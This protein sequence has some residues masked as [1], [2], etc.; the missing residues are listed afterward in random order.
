MYDGRFFH[1]F[2]RQPDISTVENTLLRYLE[3][4]DCK[5]LPYGYSYTGRTDR[6]ASSFWQT[7][8]LIVKRDC[9][10]RDFVEEINN[11]DFSIGIWGVNEYLP[12]Y[13]DARRSALWREYM[14]V[15]FEKN[16]RCKDLEFLSSMMKTLYSVRVFSFLYKDYKGLPSWY[17]DRRILRAKT[18]LF[19][20]NIVYLIRGESFPRY[21]VRRLVDFFRKMNCTDTFSEHAKRWVPGAASPEN[22][23]L[24]GAKYPFSFKKTRDIV[25]LA[26]KVFYIKK[27]FFV[28]QKIFSFLKTSS[29]LSSVL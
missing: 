26:N 11:S 18:V 7:L 15:D 6:G 21:F 24:L 23:V 17:L 16:Y 19:G 12:V 9:K 8:T 27:G 10:L 13:F 29:I 20:K 4:N 5:P 22:L 2:Q 25:E 3:E 28:S 1:G 14:Y